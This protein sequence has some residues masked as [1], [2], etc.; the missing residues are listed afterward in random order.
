MDDLEQWMKKGVEPHNTMSVHFGGYKGKSYGL[1]YHLVDGQWEVL[2]N[3]YKRHVQGTYDA[4]LDN[5]TSFQLRAAT[6]E[7]L[8]ENASSDTQ[9]HSTSQPRRAATFSSRK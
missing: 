4:I 8:S 7:I 1:K 2:H 6:R 9:H 5:D 3:V